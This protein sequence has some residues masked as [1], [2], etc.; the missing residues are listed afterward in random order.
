P[1][2]NT[3]YARDHAGIDD[4]AEDTIQPVGAQLLWGDPDPLWAVGDW[5][6]DELRVVRADA[7]TRIAV[8]GT[9]AATDAQL[10]AALYSAK[11]G[12]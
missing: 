7:E 5:R 6:P 3:S 2:R 10:R 12:A 8:L 9:C 11:G 4:Y 1:G